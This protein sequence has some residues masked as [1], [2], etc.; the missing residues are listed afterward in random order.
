MGSH[1]DWKEAIELLRPDY[2][3]LALDLPGHGGTG[4]CPNLEAYTMKGAAR[5]VAEL[6][7]ERKI[8]SCALIGYS[9]G[10]RLAL[11]MAIQHTERCSFLVMESGSPGIQSA[12]EREERRALDE[13]RAQELENSDFESF[14][15]SWY[16][17]PLFESLKRD[18]VLFKKILERR[19]NNDPVELARSLRGMGSGGHLP[20]WQD[21]SHLRTPLLILAGEM[22]LKYK[23]IAQ[24]MA[25]LS[26]KARLALVPDTGH[27][28]HAENAG[29]YVK[30]LRSFLT[31]I[32]K[33]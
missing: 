9:M 16:N 13:K 28:I 6:I 24:E 17:Q 26:P 22:D 32:R 11:H 31:P 27:N 29:E 12:V 19:R 2:Y 5:M 33:I 3:C 8:Q 25:A 21:L 30:A 20:H 14:L 4:T 7:D 23:R 15:R 1:L 18:P 10:S